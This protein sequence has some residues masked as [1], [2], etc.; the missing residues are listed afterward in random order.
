MSSL[1]QPAQK[2]PRCDSNNVST[3]NNCNTSNTNINLLSLPEE[4]LNNIL[5][6][7]LPQKECQ[8]WEWIGILSQTCTS[9]RRFAQTYAPTRIV[10]KDFINYCQIDSWEFSDVRIGFLQSL[11]DCSWK[12][13]HLKEFHV[14][15]SSVLREREQRDGEEPIHPGH[16]MIECNDIRRLLQTLITTE[17]SFSELEWLDIELQSDAVFGYNVINAE[18]LRLM[19]DALPALHKLCL[20]QCF[21]HGIRE[22]SPYRLKRF[23]TNLQ[24]PLTSLSLC[25]PTWMTDAHVEVM[26][27][28]VGENLVR[29]ELV[30]CMLWD[31]E[32]D[33]DPEVYPTDRG[34]ISI[35]EHCNQLESFSV[36]GSNITYRGLERVLSGANTGIV[37][38]NLSDSKRLEPRAVNVISRYLPH[39]KELRNYW[40][41]GSP[42]WLN[43]DDGLIAFVNAQEK[44]SYGSERI[45][46]KL[47]GLNHSSF[48]TRGIRY[49]I[50]KGVEEI[51]ID[52]GDDLL[53]SILDLGLDVKLFQAHD[54]QDYHH[55]ID[56]SYYVRKRILDF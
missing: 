55:H 28:I 46:L 32:S 8:V 30:D 49:A 10:L 47:L 27:P 53:G 25:G 13:Q 23:F 7:S 56:G 5:S 40:P 37:S 2:R 45:C 50:E 9:L 18:T 35:A 12:R 16:R 31:R 29:L 42:D 54:D 21:K 20:S 48:E 1:Q 19:P 14:D 38:L 24:T 52:M 51:E 33:D 34:M 6:Y 43:D 11:H 41:G 26:I 44:E 36:V 39:L 4:A 17:G 22:I 15:W 3:H